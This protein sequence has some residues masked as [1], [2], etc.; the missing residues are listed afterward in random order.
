MV[1]LA[2]KVAR[3]Q[4]CASVSVSV[5]LF[6]CLC[7]CVCVCVQMVERDCA[8]DSLCGEGLFSEHVGSLL[9]EGQKSRCGEG[10]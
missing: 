3:L 2:Q 8:N 5:C 9:N 10:R 1:N 7:V 4:V 6:V